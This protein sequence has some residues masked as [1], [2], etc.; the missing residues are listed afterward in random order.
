MKFT[1]TLTKFVVR[2][3]LTQLIN[4]SVWILLTDTIPI[5]KFGQLFDLDRSIT[6]GPT[7]VE[8]A[9]NV[10]CSA[11]Q[12]GLVPSLETERFFCCAHERTCQLTAEKWSPPCE[13]SDE[14]RERRF[15]YGASLD[16]NIN[17]TGRL[18]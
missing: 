9:S 16:V 12:E 5:T 10:P 2:H 6:G 15:L 14:R 13:L 11:R 1:S 7:T 4:G 17:L 18:F 3:K 8:F